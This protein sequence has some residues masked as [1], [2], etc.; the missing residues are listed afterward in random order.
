VPAPDQREQGR[1]DQPTRLRDRLATAPPAYVEGALG[2]P[3]LDEE[4]VERMLR[5]KGLPE[6]LVMR[7][8]KDDRFMRS[9]S[10]KCA[11]VRHP[12]TPRPTSMHLVKFLHWR[13]LASIC[14]D[15][16]LPPPVRTLAEQV[17]AGRLNQLPST[18]K[19]N[20][21]RTGGPALLA[22]LLRSRDMR[23]IPELLRNPRVAERD[24]IGLARER[25]T[26]S[27][28]L[29][30]L[31]RDDKWSHR[32]SVRLALVE[33]LSTP[34]AEVLRLLPEMPTAKLQ[35]IKQNPRL[36]PRLRTEATRILLGR[37]RGR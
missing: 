23:V 37:K 8:S 10:V 12:A 29:G 26:P 33:N 3:H 6:S 15:K 22:A 14:S 24:V 19:A 31:A 11:L 13:D 5:N 21:A 36:P 28:V 27:T 34:M 2:N 30:V 35:K 1:T 9:D 32:S 7:I 17:L 25:T 16:D 20:L 4:L 18:D